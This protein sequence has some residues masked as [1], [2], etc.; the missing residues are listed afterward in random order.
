M[1][2]TTRACSTDDQRLE[3]RARHEQRPHRPTH[4]AIVDRT[5]EPIDGFVCDRRDGQPLLAGM[6]Q[7]GIHFVLVQVRQ[8]REHDS[9]ARAQRASRRPRVPRE[10]SS[11]N[12]L[13]I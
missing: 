4:L 9:A 7:V 13:I 8:P 12:I 1:S 2:R 5:R 3:R 6:H 10:T 11:N